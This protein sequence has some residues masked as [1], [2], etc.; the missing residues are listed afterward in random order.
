MV[1][2]N[3]FFFKFHSIAN[4]HKVLPSKGPEDD[5]ITVFLVIILN[6]IFNSGIYEILI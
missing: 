2:E 5:K 1:A 3:F 4:I 6:F